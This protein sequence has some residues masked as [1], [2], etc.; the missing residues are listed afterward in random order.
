MKDDTLEVT[1]SFDARFSDRR[2]LQGEE[3]MLLYR[4]QANL[5]ERFWRSWGAPPILRPRSTWQDTVF[6]TRRARERT[7]ARWGPEQAGSVSTALKWAGWLDLS[8]RSAVESPE[9]NMLAMRPPLPC[10]G[11]QE[12]EARAFLSQAYW[13]KEEVFDA[14]WQRRCLKEPGREPTMLAAIVVASWAAAHWPKL[15][16]EIDAMTTECFGPHEYSGDSLV[17]MT[18]EPAPP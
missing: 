4:R 17:S 9:T 7:C 12:E 18:L 2:E 10:G 5:A 6:D 8:V 1:F 3:L 13:R 16:D 11:D 14:T 15:L